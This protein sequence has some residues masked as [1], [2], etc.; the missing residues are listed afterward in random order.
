MATTLYRLAE[1]C[2]KLLNGGDI[3]AATNVSINEVKISICQVANSLLKVEH[4]NVNEK[5]G[6]KID[7]GGV[8]AL[9]ENIQCSTWN[10]TTKA[11]LPIKPIKLP[12]N[13]GVFG[14]YPKYVLGG[15]YEFNKEWIPMQMGVGG[16]LKSQPLISDILGQVG[17]ENFG[18][19]I[20]ATKDMKSLYPDMVLA[21]RLAIMDLSQYDDYSIFPVL[22]EQEWQI[23]QEIV[24]LYSGEQV[25]D[26]V[27]DV[28]TAQQ[29]GIPL[30]QQ[31]QTP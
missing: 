16:L 22:P 29:Q 17:Y 20:I 6:E 14:V 8:L 25:S 13:M 31:A 21:M 12:R 9:Y 3:Q 26:K 10:G 23:K 2:L 15:N 30:K 11:V 28:T 7:N 1:E 4:F 19:D 5:L 27:V 18:L 24:K